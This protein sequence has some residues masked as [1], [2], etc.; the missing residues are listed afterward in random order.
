MWA[1]KKPPVETMRSTRPSAPRNAA[2]T[3]SNRSGSAVSRPTATPATVSARA[4]SPR[5]W[6]VSPTVSSEPMLS[7]SAVGD[8]GRSPV[9]RNGG[10]R[11][12]AQ[13]GDRM[14]AGRCYHPGPEGE[15]IQ[16]RP[17]P[18]PGDQRWTTREPRPRD[19]RPAGDRPPGLR[20]QIVAVRDAAV[21]MA[22]AHVELAKAEATEIGYQIA[23]V[24]GLI[25]LAVVLV[26]FAV[27]LIIVG[28]SLFLSEWLLG[29]IGWGISARNPAL[30]RGRRGQRPAGRRHRRRPARPSV[31]PRRARR[32]GPLVRVRPIGYST[33]CTRR[34]R[35]TSRLA[36]TQAPPRS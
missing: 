27:N 17:P 36:S 19:D 16:A 4:S 26:L 28:T 25:G 18:V 1:P 9:Q 10:A 3:S 34:S 14:A 2:A 15:P 11:L 31:R 22:L 8:D 6:R 7:S 29:S 5:T 12:P 33:S 35:A 32:R 24:A 13:D 21:R 30:H 23:R 20:A